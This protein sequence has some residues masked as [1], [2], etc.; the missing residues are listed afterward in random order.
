VIHRASRIATA[1]RDPQ[2]VRRDHRYACVSSRMA[3]S[4]LCGS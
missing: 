1:G 3:S 4:M 2:V